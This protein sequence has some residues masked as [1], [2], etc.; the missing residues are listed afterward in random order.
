MGRFQNTGSPTQ[1]A[2]RRGPWLGPDFLVSVQKVSALRFSPGCPAG[3]Q[4]PGF[5]TSSI[6]SLLWGQPVLS[7]TVV[8]GS[9][10]SQNRPSSL[11]LPLAGPGM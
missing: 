4:A 10:N 1:G 11:A 6:S 5:R 9:A 2:R 3:S 7:A 8:W